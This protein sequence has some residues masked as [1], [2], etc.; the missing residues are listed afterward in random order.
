MG[1]VFIL[2]AY[3]MFDPEYGTTVLFGTSGTFVMAVGSL[4]LG[5]IVME[6][7]ARFSGPADYFAGRSLNRD[8]A[9]L[10]PE[11]P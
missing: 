10:V 2:S 8:T 11:E 3:Y 7:Y 1:T 4:I 9:V 6:V 5:I